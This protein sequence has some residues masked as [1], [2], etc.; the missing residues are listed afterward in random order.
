MKGLWKP[1]KI[2]KRK[3]IGKSE[4]Y[5]QEFTDLALSKG[6]TIKVTGTLAFKNKKGQIFKL[7]STI[8]GLLNVYDESIKQQYEVLR[9]VI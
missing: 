2:P 6:F 9:K 7:V 8:G 5:W 4:Q 3:T 1:G